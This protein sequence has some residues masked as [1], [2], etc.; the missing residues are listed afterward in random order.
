MFGRATIRLGIGP[1]SSLPWR[2][3]ANCS[4]H[5]NSAEN[6]CGMQLAD[7]SVG[8]DNERLGCLNSCVIKMISV[9]SLAFQH[10]QHS[11]MCRRLAAE[12]TFC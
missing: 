12:N 3:V 4:M 8:L 9:K 6:Y 1:H 10:R 2:T 7:K 11:I 5:T